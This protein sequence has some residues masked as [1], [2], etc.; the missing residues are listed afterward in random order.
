MA[1]L[2]SLLSALFLT[3]AQL[4]CV[5]WGRKNNNPPPDDPGAPTLAFVFSPTFDSPVYTGERGWHFKLGRIPVVQAPT[6]FRLSGP[7][8]LL[9]IDDLNVVPGQEYNWSGFDG[10]YR[11]PLN[12]ADV[13]AEGLV[14]KVGCEVF[15]PFSKRWERSPDY[16]IR[17]LPKTT[18][19]TF[20]YG[21]DP[22]TET[23]VASGASK[24]FAV[25]TEPV[26][27][28]DINLRVQVI[29]P[30][31]YAGPAPSLVVNDHWPSRLWSM[32][33]TAPSG[34]TS[35][36]DFIIRT[37]I[38]DPW[39]GGPRSVDFTFHVTPN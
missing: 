39:A 12:A 31:N 32:T 27:V 6:R 29:P 16:E 19:M 9:D 38:D 33:F 30:E 34:I 24:N 4:D 21:Y 13:P 35:P 8:V 18:P 26:P 25:R 3:L 17:V 15:S 20:H 7:G 22:V 5:D 2:F 23:S 1:R 11:P 10:V 28:Q 36:T 37:T 14:V